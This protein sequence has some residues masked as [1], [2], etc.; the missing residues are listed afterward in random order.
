MAIISEYDILKFMS[1]IPES[2]VIKLRRIRQLRLLVNNQLD[3]PGIYTR[4]TDNQ[5]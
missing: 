5:M 3:L 1:G 2:M 4:F